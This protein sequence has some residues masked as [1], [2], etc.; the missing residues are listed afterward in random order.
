LKEYGAAMLF[1]TRVNS[2]QMFLKRTAQAGGRQG[3]HGYVLSASGISP[4]QKRRIK[5]EGVLV[6][7]AKVD[8]VKGIERSDRKIGGRRVERGC[9]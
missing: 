4:K 2:L 8:V 1:E 7:A 3:V 6:K 9:E 5:M